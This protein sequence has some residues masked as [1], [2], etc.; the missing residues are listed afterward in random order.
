MERK[1]IA[2]IQARTSS[3][4]L[5]KKV[6]MKTVNK[7]IIIHQLQ[8]TVKSKYIDDLV[9]LTSDKK[10]D[11]ELANIV[12]SS[13]FNIF[14]GSELNV[15][16]RFYKSLEE[17]NLKSDD[18]IVRLTGDCPIHD[19]HIIDESIIAFLNNNCDYL[20]NAIAPIY[21]DGLDVEVFFYDTL[22]KAYENATEPIDLEHVTPYIRNSNSFKVME[23]EKTPLYPDW[24][25][26]V[27]EPKDFILID[28]IFNHFENSDF[29]FLDVVRFIEDNLDL[30]KLNKNYIRNEGFLHPE[31]DSRERYKVSQGNQIYIREIEYSDVNE[32]YYNWMND[33]EVNRYMETR[34]SSQTIIEIYNF[35]KKIK[36]DTNS[37]L[38]AICDN[39][40]KH[41]GNIKIGPINPIHKKADISFFIGEKSYWSKGC[42]YEAVS[43]VKEYA[44]DV[45]K[46]HKLCAGV[47]ENNIASVKMLE[48]NG[49]K[50]EGIKKKEGLVDN[51]WSDIYILGIINDK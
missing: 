49:F 17:Y 24:R 4:R 20:S 43:L 12:T 31:N 1:I 21:P 25:L 19:S 15:L 34:H 48:R 27:D 41:I 8:R 46:L 36:E 28:K 10:D 22:K 40:D 35:V 6:L 44:F 18:I 2:L 50:I 14:R 26:T 7:P 33:P 11:D 51:K 47:Y 3:K 30:L 37:I 38:F 45:L 42:T 23:L 32:S 5:P 29:S 39:S 13:G 9:L 16:E